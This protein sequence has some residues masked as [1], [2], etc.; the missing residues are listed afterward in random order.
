MSNVTIAINATVRGFA[1]MKPATT[2]HTL[3]TCCS[4]MQRNSK[5]VVV[6]F[7]TTV[8]KMCFVHAAILAALSKTHEI[9][10]LVL[11]KGLIKHEG[12][13]NL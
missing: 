1:A 10:P 5:C 9:L 4:P 13:E 6:R 2:C 7:A 3:K 11:K 8:T 12:L